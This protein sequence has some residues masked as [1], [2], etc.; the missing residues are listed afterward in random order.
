MKRLLCF[1]L[2]H[3][4]KILAK[5]KLSEI[6]EKMNK[7]Y[8]WA[9][10]SFHMNLNKDFYVINRRCLRCNKFDNNIDEARKLVRTKILN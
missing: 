4:W 5:I 2:G 1:I 6:A 3:K 10:K 9:S 7:E 8:W